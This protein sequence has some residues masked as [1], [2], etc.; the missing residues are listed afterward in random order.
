MLDEDKTN[1]QLIAELHELR[2][3]LAESE[4]DI[5]ERK[6]IEAGLEKARKELEATKIS[7]DEA[8]EYAESIINTIREPLIAL[9]HDLRVVTVSRSFY[10]FFKVKPDETVGRLIYDLGDGQWDIPKLREL[11]ET[12]LPQKATFDNFE[13]EHDF[14]AI[15]KRIMLL[16]ARQIKRV[17]GKERIILLA[18]EDIT[19]RKRLE[20][21]LTESEERYRRL[22]E[23]ASDGIVLLEKR[24]G[25]ITHANPASEKMLG[26]A[27]EECVGNSLQDIGI[28][29]DMGDFQTTMQDLN[30]SGIIYYNDVPVITKSGQHIDTD[31]YL[32]DRA[33]LVQC[34]IRDISERKVAE[35]NLKESKELTEAVVENVPLMIFLK[36]STDLR[37]VI[38]NR[39]GEELLGYDRRDLIGKN[40]L[41]LFPPDQ[42]AHFMAKDREVLDGEIGMLDIP[43]EPILTAKKGLR[44]LHTRKVVVQG[45]DGATKFLLGISEDITERKRAE[46]ALTHSE[47]QLRFLSSRLLEAQEEERRRIAGELHDSIGQSL[48]AIKFNVENVLKETGKDLNG[49]IENS[50]QQII[51]LVQNSME[52]VRRIYTGLRPSILD[53]LGIIATIG[54]YCRECQKTY[55][56]ICFEHQ[57]GIEEEEISEPLKIVIFRIVQEALN[58]IAK[59]SG[60]ELV[61]VCLERKDGRIE[62]AIVDNGTGFDVDSALVKS[63]REKGFGITWMKERTEFAGGTFNIE[64]VIGKGTTVHATWPSNGGFN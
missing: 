54:W 58:N 50:L 32:V 4:K 60:A 33:R 31:I 42:A 64:S 10:D 9:D 7:E 30:R 15:G 48:A 38:F 11:L 57:M 41:D 63:S 24:E 43:E 22:F 28:S 44:L 29:L 35:V 14:A 62:L 3:R 61:N 39:A 21:L 23:T 25:K 59:H 20:S 27:K 6:E 13:V 8:R 47:E 56:G 1:E 40:D 55:I 17:L 46:E 26:Y 37:F 36:E 49:R 52:E 12:I 19:E 51:P 2:Q 53:D 5:T 16:N 45:S 34:N 18:I